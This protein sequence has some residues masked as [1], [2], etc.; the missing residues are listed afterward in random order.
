MTALAENP[1]GMSGPAVAGEMDYF[2]PLNKLAAGAMIGAQVV[3]DELSARLT[4]LGTAPGGCYHELPLVEGSLR[5]AVTKLPQ[6]L[7]SRP[8]PIWRITINQGKELT[9]LNNQPRERIAL[10]DHWIGPG[11]RF[12]T[13]TDSVTYNGGNRESVPIGTDLPRIVRARHGSYLLNNAYA[14]IARLPRLP[15]RLEPEQRFRYLES[16]MDTVRGLLAEPLSQLSDD[17]LQT[18]EPGFIR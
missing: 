11:F 9:P 17:T 8:N 14:N 12:R 3:S 1:E 16:Y 15:S 4:E 6:V 7:C 10:T 2:G 5:V 18:A 13:F